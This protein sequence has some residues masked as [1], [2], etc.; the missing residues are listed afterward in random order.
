MSEKLQ[1]V[2]AALGQGSRRA[3]EEYIKSGLVS[4]DGKVASLGDRVEGNEVIRVNGQIVKAANSTKPICRVLVYN[5]PEGQMCTRKDPQGRPTVFDRLPAVSKG[6][7]LYVGRLD[8]NTS[9]LLLFTTDGELS[10]CLM[11]P[12]HEIERVY[13][14]RVFGEVTKEHIEKL[15]TKI[16]LDDGP[17]HFDK[18][19]YIGGEGINQWYN[20]TLK[21]GRKREVRRLWE[22]LGLKVSRLKRISYANIELG[23]LPQGSWRELTLNEVN[24]LRA[25]VNLRP[26]KESVVEDKKLSVREEFVRNRQVRHA[27]KKFEKKTGFNKHKKLNSRESNFE[28]FLEE[29]RSFH[30]G[31]K[32][33][34]KKSD[35]RFLKGGSKERS[36]KDD[37]KSFWDK[38][39]YK[40]KTFNTKESKFGKKLVRDSFRGEKNHFRKD[41]FSR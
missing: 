20:V 27:V 6:R 17:A 24:E 14:V 8:V 18:V 15:Q 36:P 23:K 16:D 25:L 32:D 7:W 30:K 40:G 5:K 37:N 11:H 10:N 33:D 29:E 39:V 41:T 3:M 13:A 28:F 2:L 4:V 35:A 9:G 31:R 26:E 21:E 22:A 34:R 19:S 1:K 38:N 12:S